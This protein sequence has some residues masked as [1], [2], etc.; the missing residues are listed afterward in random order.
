[1]RFV[2]SYAVRKKWKKQGKKQQNR[3]FFQQEF[4]NLSKIDMFF[5]KNIKNVVFL[6]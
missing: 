6:F 4:T 1:M 3:Y 2:T 5:L